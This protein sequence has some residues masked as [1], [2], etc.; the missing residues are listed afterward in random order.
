MPKIGKIKHSY[1]CDAAHDMLEKCCKVGAELEHNLVVIRRFLDDSYVRKLFNEH[2]C[3]GSERIA[4]YYSRLKYSN[5]TLAP[6]DYAALI[7][8]AST[9]SE[10]IGYLKALITIAQDR[11]E[12][13][14]HLS[15]AKTEEE[16]EQILVL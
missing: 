5:V 1:Y 7:W 10:Y 11:Y 2:H 12:L 16:E 4:G 9:M 8:D 6:A 15:E 14:S 13:V 3:E